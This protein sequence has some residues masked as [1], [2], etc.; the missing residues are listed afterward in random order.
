[1][2]RRRGEPQSTAARPRVLTEMELNDF[3]LVFGLDGGTSTHQGSTCGPNSLAP[4]STPTGPLASY[5]DQSRGGGPRSRICR[6]QPSGASA[7][8]HPRDLRWRTNATVVVGPPAAIVSRDKPAFHFT[9][10]AATRMASVRGEVRDFFRVARRRAGVQQ[11]FRR[12]SAA[13]S[14]AS[15]RAGWIGM[16]LAQALRR[17]DAACSHLCR[18]LELLAAFAPRRRALDRRPAKRA[19]LLAWHQGSASR[20]S[21]GHLPRERLDLGGRP[22]PSSALP[23]CRILLALAGRRASASCPAEAW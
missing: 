5:V 19:P 12:S 10:R 23:D 4:V 6:A 15:A 11:R 7:R 22:P 16:T 9:G 8:P 21:A 17:G 20:L 3:K 18:D 13:G 14:A 1:L 2:V